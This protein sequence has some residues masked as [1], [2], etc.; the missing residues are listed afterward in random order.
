MTSLMCGSAVA[1]I[2]PT[3]ESWGSVVAIVQSTQEWKPLGQRSSLSPGQM[4]SAARLEV[5]LD[6]VAL[7]TDFLTY[8]LT[9][10]EWS[11]DYYIL[12]NMIFRMML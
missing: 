5:S 10:S 6:H 2:R 9:I 11:D 1:I 3:L 12:Q 8:W 4:W 7:G